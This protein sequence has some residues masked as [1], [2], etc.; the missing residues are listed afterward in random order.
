MTQHKQLLA[1][2]AETPCSVFYLEKD[3]VEEL[4]SNYEDAYVHLKQLADRRLAELRKA[5]GAQ[6]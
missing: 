4:V 5:T 6:F 3:D 1:Y 2:R